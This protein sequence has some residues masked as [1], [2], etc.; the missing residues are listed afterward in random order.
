[1]DSSSPGWKTF[2]ITP[3]AESW[4]QGWTNHGLR[5]TLTNGKQ[6]LSCEGMYS[7]GDQNNTLPLLVV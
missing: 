4:K 1:M 5:V 7:S 6:E 3:I 2:D